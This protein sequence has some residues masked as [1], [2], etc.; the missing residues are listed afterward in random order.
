M[1][2]KCKLTKALVR[3]LCPC[4]LGTISLRSSSLKRVWRIDLK[5][6]KY[7]DWD[8]MRAFTLTFPMQRTR[9]RETMTVECKFITGT[10]ASASFFGEECVVVSDCM[11]IRIKVFCAEIP[12][13]LLVQALLKPSN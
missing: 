10:H 8:E 12:G 7:L 1:L 9:G 4:L 11:T 13:S 3:V 6:S 2:H 5:Y